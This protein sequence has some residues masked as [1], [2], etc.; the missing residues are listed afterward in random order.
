M[1]IKFD[2]RWLNHRRRAFR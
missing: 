2:D 1:F